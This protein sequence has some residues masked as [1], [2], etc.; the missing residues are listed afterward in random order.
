MTHS[1]VFNSGKSDCFII[2]DYFSELCVKSTVN[3]TEYKKN[4]IQVCIIMASLSN[5][6]DNPKGKSS[7]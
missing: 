3:K 2:I 4:G 6:Q 5:N 7:Q 1:Q